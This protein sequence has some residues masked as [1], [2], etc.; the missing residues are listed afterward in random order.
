MG[1]GSLLPTP[2]PQ[3]PS[4]PSQGHYLF[5]CFLCDTLR[6]YKDFPFSLY[7]FNII[8]LRKIKYKMPES[9]VVI[10]QKKFPLLRSTCKSSTHSYHYAL[11]YLRICL[12][13]SSLDSHAVC[14]PVN[15]GQDT[16]CDDAAKA[17]SHGRGQL[18][19]GLELSSY[20]GNYLLS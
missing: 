5:L 19:Q 15:S 16:D 17:R 1:G 8:F 13:S 14:Y 18:L 3:S 9:T 12:L 2:L 20:R 4:F 10:T 6:L 11:H 7:Y